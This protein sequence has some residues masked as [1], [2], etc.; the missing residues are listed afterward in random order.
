VELG[1]ERREGREKRGRISY[2]RTWRCTEG[3]EIEQNC[4]AM[5]DEELGVATRKFQMPKKKKKKKNQELSRT[6]LE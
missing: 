3:Q 4:V 1:R 6:P 2:G 5:G